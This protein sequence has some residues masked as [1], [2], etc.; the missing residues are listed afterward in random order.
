MA[1]LRL[2]K[3]TAKDDGGKLIQIHSY[4]YQLVE[5]LNWALDTVQTGNTTSQQIVSANT[6]GALSE[7]AE[8]QKSFAAIKSL[9]I[10]SAD[11]V[12]AY[13]DEI[14]A[15]LEGIYVAQ[16]DFGT[17]QQQTELNFEATSSAIT[18]T[19]N[20]LQTLQVLIDE[21]NSTLG[22]KINELQTIVANA[23]IKSGLL[24]ETEQGVPIYGLEVGE[25]VTVDGVETFNKFA[26]FTSDRISFYDQNGT[27]V[28]YVSDYK[29]YIY[30]AEFL[31]RIKIG[32]F[33]LDSTDGLAFSW[34]GG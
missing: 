30:E 15:R 24:E 14:N 23:Y 34:I 18:E 29:L 8:A 17:Y 31:G 21:V 20:N 12:Q 3:I 19:F 16:S 11:I 22:D 28:A 33:R 25:R 26:R 27:E 10:K 32:N 1:S 6:G 9:I 2:P 13:Y 5:E 7:E 4:L